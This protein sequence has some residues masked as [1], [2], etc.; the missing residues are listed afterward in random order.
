MDKGP[1]TQHHDGNTIMIRAEAIISFGIT[2]DKG[3][4]EVVHVVIPITRSIHVESS[5][6]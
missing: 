1:V 3:F 2:L 6:T 4:D 5:A